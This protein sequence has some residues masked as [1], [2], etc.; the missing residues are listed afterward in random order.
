MLVTDHQP[1]VAILHP[2][3]GVSGIIAVCMQQWD[4]FLAHDIEYKRTKAHGNA[5]K[6]IYLWKSLL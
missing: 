3:K 4:L 6:L 1:L 5:D 2:K